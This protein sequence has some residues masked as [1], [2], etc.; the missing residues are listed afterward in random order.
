MAGEKTSEYPVAA[1]VNPTDLHDISQGATSRSATDYLVRGGVK[2]SKVFGDFSNASLEF[3][4]E[5]FTLKQARKWIEVVMKHEV[6]WSGGSISAV[7]IEIGI[8]GELDKFVSVAF[9]INQAPGDQVFQLE[10]T[11]SV[12]DW[13]NDTSIRANVRAIGDDLDQLN[14]GSIDFYIF[15]KSMKPS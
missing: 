11:P 14:A 2:V 3:D 13:N 10:I 5:I 12:E 7:E 1:E 8:V 15:T 9:D 4:I 6:A